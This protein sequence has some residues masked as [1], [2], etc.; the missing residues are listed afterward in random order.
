VGALC[1]LLCPASV[2]DVLKGSFLIFDELLIHA[3]YGTFFR[4]D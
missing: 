4:R 1:F 2:H 3:H